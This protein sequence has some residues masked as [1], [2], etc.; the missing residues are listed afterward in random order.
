VSRSGDVA[1]LPRNGLVGPVGSAPEISP[2]HTASFLNPIP[3]VRSSHYELCR[4]ISSDGRQAL[5]PRLHCLKTRRSA[6]HRG[7]GM[8]MPHDLKA[9]RQTL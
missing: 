4:K 3:A 1:V 8:P 7:V 9:D 2:L 6:E 5:R